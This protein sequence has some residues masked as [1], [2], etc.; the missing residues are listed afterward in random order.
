MRPDDVW[1]ID[2]I[3]AVLDEPTEGER[4]RYREIQAI[5]LIAGLALAGYLAYKQRYMIATVLAV[6]VASPLDD[7]ALAWLLSRGK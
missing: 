5:A 6:V 1:W 7:M 3:T 4:M 2:E